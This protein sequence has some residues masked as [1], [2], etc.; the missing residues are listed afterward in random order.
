MYVWMN[1]WICNILN[2]RFTANSARQSETD[3]KKRK[4]KKNDVFNLNYKEDKEFE[5]LFKVKCF[6]ITSLNEEPKRCF[7]KCKCC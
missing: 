1:E 5:S 3:T 4:D 7:T 6:I 2:Y